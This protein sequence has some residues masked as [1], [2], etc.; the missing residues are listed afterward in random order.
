[1]TLPADYVRDHVRRGYAATE[2]GWQS[3]TVDTAIALTSSD[4]TRRGLYVAATR[5]RDENVLCVVTDSDEALAQQQHGHDLPAVKPRFEV[6]DWFP[7]LHDAR[8][9]LAAAEQ[10]HAARAAHRE[11][12]QGAVAAAE[13]TR[14]EVAAATSPDRDAY[15]HA[16]ARADEAK[17]EHA[18]AKHQLAAAP[19]RQR[20]AARHT[21]EVAEQRLERAEAYLERTRQRTQPGIDQYNQALTE[22][23]K[24]QDN[25]GFSNMADVLDSLG[26]PIDV[27]RR[28]VAAL[29]AWHRWAAGERIEANLLSDAT[30]ALDDT[31][32]RD[33]ARAQD[34]RRQPAAMGPWTGRRTARCRRGRVF[35]LSSGC[36]FWAG[37]ALHGHLSPHPCPAAEPISTMLRTAMRWPHRS[38]NTPR[39]QTT[40]SPRAS[41]DPLRTPVQRRSVRQARGLGRRRSVALAGGPS[42]LA[43]P[44]SERRVRAGR[45][46]SDSSRVRRSP[47]PTGRQASRRPNL[48]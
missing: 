45:V 24:A 3:D 32:G 43:R 33:A 5:G 25:V 28:R 38:A 34:A 37:R 18:S 13:R 9:E 20:R 15:A 14:V 44:R 17:Q 29:E 16:A 23:R 36:D 35:Q 12:I 39:P 8:R 30:E 10:Q 11:R 27:L 2:H 4:T 6:P 26:L 40:P 48:V 21:A 7:L 42:Q 1:M 19:R 31:P 46:R 22:R 47:R 41:R